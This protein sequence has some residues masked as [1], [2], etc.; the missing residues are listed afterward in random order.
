MSTFRLSLTSPPT[1]VQTKL[2][3]L[4]AESALI[5]ARREIND[6]E[7]RSLVKARLPTKENRIVA[8]ELANQARDNSMALID[9]GYAPYRSRSTPPS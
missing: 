7:Y 9:F 2:A 5:E 4:L 8:D 1:E 6:N 3:S